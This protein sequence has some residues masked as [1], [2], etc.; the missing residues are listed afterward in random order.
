MD[1]N[2][3]EYVHLE[4]FNRELVKHPVIHVISALIHRPLLKPFAYF[5]SRVTIHLHEVNHHVR[6]VL[7]GATLFRLLLAL[8]IVRSIAEMLIILL[9]NECA[10]APCLLLLL[11]MI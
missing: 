8:C 11:L 7:L 4:V 5:V 2:H 9:N 10:Y 1:P 6:H 3:V